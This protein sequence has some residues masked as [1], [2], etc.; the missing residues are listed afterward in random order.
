MRGR[1]LGLPIRACTD[2]AFGPENRFPWIPHPA[3]QMPRRDRE[4]RV[5]SRDSPPS[6]EAAGP[7]AAHTLV[8][9]T[10][11]VWDPPEAA[12]MHRCALLSLAFSVAFTLV[13]S[14]ADDA[15]ACHVEYTLKE[16]DT[17]QSI[18]HQIYN[19]STKWQIIYYANQDRLAEHSSLLRPGTSIRLPCAAAA[20]PVPTPSTPVP[21]DIQITGVVVHREPQDIMVPF[22]LTSVDGVGRKIGFILA[23]NTR[24]SVGTREEIALSLL[25]TLEGLPPGPHAFHV[26]SNPNCGP[27][28][29]DGKVVPGLGAGPHLFLKGTGHEA[30]ITYLS[31]LGNL[32]NLLSWV[33]G[34]QRARLP[35]R[36]SHWMISAAARSSSILAKM[37]PQLAT[38]V[39][40][41]LD[42]ARLHHMGAG[43]K[44]C[45]P[46]R[47]APHSCCARV[48]DKSLDPSR[49]SGR[50]AQEQLHSR[51]RSACRISRLSLMA[52]PRPL[53]HGRTC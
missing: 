8:I 46:H 50:P 15:Q 20:T 12:R 51:S 36:G 38:P 26:H 24:I 30:G 14:V 18:A 42:D 16:N 11:I 22:H 39:V 32:P 52:T 29:E 28:E 4:I 25:P 19:D 5:P 2:V 47:C 45:L 7:Q 13:L 35:Y 31:H 3:T 40:L 44:A 27:G 6:D 41:C 10:L 34:G 21:Q 53:E 9:I 48:Q 37:T 23:R 43:C 1:G 49:A 33:T 17:L